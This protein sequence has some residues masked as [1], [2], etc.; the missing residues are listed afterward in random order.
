MSQKLITKAGASE[1]SVDAEKRI[2]ARRIRYATI[3]GEAGG[4]LRVNYYYPTKDG[5]YAVV[6][7]ADRFGGKERSQRAFE[8]AACG[9]D[10]PCDY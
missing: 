2:R 8:A 1:F 9:S 4:V 5:G 3:T 6:A 10:H 7:G